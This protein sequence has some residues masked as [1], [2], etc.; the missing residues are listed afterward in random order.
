[1]ASQHYEQSV[2][3]PLPDAVADVDKEERF[4]QEYLKDRE[5]YE[6]MSEDDFLIDNLLEGVPKQATTKLSVQPTRF[7]DVLSEKEIFEKI[8]SAVP[9][10]TKKSTAWAVNVWC[11]WSDYR[12]NKSEDVP[13]SLEG[14]GNEQLSCWLPRLILEARNKKG[15]QYIGRSLYCLCAAIQR[16]VREERVRHNGATV[17]IFKD[18]VSII[19]GEC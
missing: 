11:D 1:M 18:Q 2:K 15:E 10:S 13:P 16:F 5:V 9:R 19:L 12:A 17:D 6:D 4:V 3:D 8:E 14:I 7:G